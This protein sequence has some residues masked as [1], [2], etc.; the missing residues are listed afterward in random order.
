MT[1]VGA[2]NA[3]DLFVGGR[4]STPGDGGSF[5]L[6][7][8]D[9]AP[10]SSTAV[11]AGLQQNAAM[12]SNLAIVNGGP[13]PV[14]LRVKLEGPLGEDLGVL[15][16][17]T[18]PAWGWKQFDRPLEGKATSG[19]AVVTRVSGTS[20]VLGLRRPERRRHVGRL[21]RPA[22]RSR[23]RRVRRTG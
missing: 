8:S 15:S 12:R 18:L 1:L 20:P 6:F 3:A 19:R 21:L 5:G 7:Y 2:T 16:D 9:A 22:A 4:T 14:T 10:T 23:G 13:E 17:W 11:V